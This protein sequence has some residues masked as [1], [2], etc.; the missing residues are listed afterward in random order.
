MLRSMGKLN[1]HY[2]FINIYAH[3]KTFSTF[4]PVSKRHDSMG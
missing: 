4:V 2:Q 3:E 1:I